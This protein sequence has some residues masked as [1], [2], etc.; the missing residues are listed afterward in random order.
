MD[1]KPKA[2]ITFEAVASLLKAAAAWLFTLLISWLVFMGFL[3]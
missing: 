1:S 3:S 2:A